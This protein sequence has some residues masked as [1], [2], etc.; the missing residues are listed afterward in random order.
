M[1]ICLFTQQEIT[2]PLSLRDSRGEHLI[3]ILHKKEG[4]SF[5]AGI[6][7]GMAGKAT[8]TKI[9]QTQCTSPDGRKSFTEGSLEFTFEPLTDGKPLYPLIMIIGFPRPIQLKR[10]MRDLAGLG[11]CE[12]H[13]TG[14][15]LGEKSYL[16]SNLASGDEGYQMLLEGT[17]QAASTH[18]PLL[19]KHDSLKECLDYIE[20]NHIQGKDPQLTIQKYALDNIT[21]SGSLYD[22]VTSTQPDIA[23]GAIGSERGWTQNERQLMENYG[24]S[25][26]S[27]GSRVLRT[28]SAAT[29]AASL[30]L[31]AMGK[32]D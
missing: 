26:L 7:N 18:V 19:F 30:I 9:Q 28:E 6:I 4:D 29:V 14:T 11:V 25:R 3:K 13:L 23:I 22:A 16:K 31:G 12:I 20:E 1:N 17:V 10:L 8:I 5:E 21:P 24:Y 2:K 32:L 15:E 27:M